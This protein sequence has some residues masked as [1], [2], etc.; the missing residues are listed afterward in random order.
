MAIIIV[1]TNYDGEVLEKLLTKASTG[2]ELVQKGLIRLEPEV[3]KKFSIP[4]MKTGKMLQKR[5]EM[6]KLSDS[7]GDFKYDEKELIPMDF[8][9]FTTFNPRTF[10]KIW[11]KWQPKGNLVFL[12]LPPEGQNELLNEMG[13][14]V[15]FELGGHFINGVYGDDDDHLFNG[16]L[17]RM[18]ADPEVIRVKTKETSMIKKM[19]AIRQATPEVL[20]NDPRFKYIMSVNDA[21]T[22]DNELTAQTAKGAN[23]TDQNAQ[24]FKNTTIVPLSQ[25]PD[26]VI[27]GTIATMDIDSNTWGAVNLQDDMDVIQIDKLENAGELYFFKMLMTADTNIAFGEE[28]VLMDTRENKAAKLTGTTVTVSAY[29]SAIEATPAADASWNI[30][31]DAA[32][33]GAHLRVVNKSADKTI[34]IGDV[35]IGGGKTVDLY[36]DGKAWFSSDPDAGSVA[37]EVLQHIDE[38]DGN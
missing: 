29:S 10:Q 37:A 24:R 12:E 15:N 36:F 14:V 17:T 20:R 22:Y 11:R 34:T 13:K 3:T 8:M 33:L 21:D 38:E 16:I 18:L 19:Q 9:A 2:N 4:R 25:W 30:T 27:I 26:G 6:P 7:K 32:V 35:M 31:G 28:V 23:W 5:K 1:N